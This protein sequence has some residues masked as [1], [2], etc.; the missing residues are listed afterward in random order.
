MSDP[1]FTGA[2]VVKSVD[3][4]DSL[5]IYE[6]SKARGGRPPERQLTL[7]MLS[8]PRL[9]KTIDGEEDWS[10]PSRE[11]LR[12][13]CIGKQVNFTVEH[14]IEGTDGRRAREFGQVF[15]GDNNLALSVAAAGWAR[16]R[17]P[18]DGKPP[19]NDFH[20]E[21]IEASDKAEEAGLGIFQKDTSEA[22]RSPLKSIDTM[23]FFDRYKNTPQPAQIEYIR[24]GTCLRVLMLNGFHKFTLRI[25]GAEAPNIPPPHKKEQ[26][27]P[28]ADEAKFFVER[29]LLQRDVQITIRIPG[30]GAHAE[31]FF[32]SLTMDGRDLAEE[33]LRQGLAR[34]IE[35]NA[36]DVPK[37]RALEQQAKA[38][39]LRI[40]K[41]AQ[42]A[43]STVES[44]EMS[45]WNG[46]V[47][48]V[49]DGNTL[50]IL[51]TSVDPPVKQTV[52]LSSVRA[53]KLGSYGKPDEPY[54]YEAK[55]LLRNKLIGKKVRVVVD[56][57]RKGTPVPGKEDVILPPREFCTVYLGNTSAA[58]FLVEEGLAKVTSAKDASLSAAY[59]QLIIEEKRAKAKGKNM[60][61][62]K[63][64][65]PIHRFTDLSDSGKGEKSANRVNKAK[66]FLPSL[67]RAGRLN[68]VVEWVVNASRIK[69]RIPK[70]NCIILFS[71]ECVR[72]P[73]SKNNDPCADECTEFAK[74]KLHQRDVQ[75]IVDNV[76]PRGNFVGTLWHNKRNFSVTLLENG[77][78][79]VHEPSLNFTS[80]ANEY[81]EAERRAKA[82]KLHIWKHSDNPLQRAKPQQVESESEEI[83]AQTSKM[84]HV[85]V[86]EVVDGGWFYLQLTEELPKLNTM[87][88]ELNG[89]SRVLAPLGDTQ[90]KKGQLVVAKFDDGKWYRAKF[91]GK[92]G[93]KYNVTFVDYGNGTSVSSGDIRLIPSDFTTTPPF[94]KECTL[95][96]VR[97]PPFDSEYGPDSAEFFHSLVWEK[98]LVAGFESKRGDLNIVTLGD[99]RTEKMVNIDMVYAGYATVDNRALRNNPVL[100]K[101]LKSAQDSA[102]SNHRGMFEYGDPFDDD[103]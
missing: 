65:P 29:F 45:E 5:V 44:P 69:V 53:P 46:K 54:S 50:V 92:Q 17:R 77:F 83:P 88:A 38:A 8:A 76:D 97:V 80:Y 14:K 102:H 3:S 60:W 99:P 15:V 18:Q 36:P 24:D 13:A 12:K 42:K 19:K 47:R 4:G 35:W 85:Q 71:L 25:A 95:A 16:V 96:Y 23:S 75:V 55:E 58:L 26:P 37:M 90:L 74:E 41:F 59:E 103:Y 6:V 72:T 39:K 27:A 63:Q 87:M 89:G 33:L 48:E 1:S 51:N 34:F 81:T 61:N 56:E 40:W 91:E 84:V 22:K 62:D 78:A 7:S 94:A 31:E 100:A 79:V 20:K 98:P 49:R 73:S 101:N 82:S 67:Q 21:L 64:Q 86:S 66:Q 57:V 52:S 43:A 11:F 30:Q 9:G 68:A 32:G 2:G 93:D 10:W 70:E 28:F